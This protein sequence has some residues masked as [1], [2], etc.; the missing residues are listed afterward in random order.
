MAR[1]RE[2]GT[3]VSVDSRIMFRKLWNMVSKKKEIDTNIFDTA[4][5]TDI[6]RLFNSPS[7]G[8]SPVA[9]ACI[10]ILTDNIAGSDM[11]VV[12]NVSNERQPQ[13]EPILEH[14]LKLLLDNP[15]R[16]WD[17][18]SFWNW[19]FRCLFST[20]NA[21][22][23]I[24]RKGNMGRAVELVPAKSQ[25]QLEDGARMVHIFE[26]GQWV[27]QQRPVRSQD[28]LEMHL[29]D[30]DGA[31]AISPLGRAAKV[32]DL[33]NAIVL[34][35][36]NMIKK[37]LHFKT[38]LV[39]DVMTPDKTPEQRKAISDAIKEYSSGVDSAGKMLILP[40]GM[41]PMQ[42]G[43]MSA[44]DMQIMNIL[45]WGILEI[46]R[47]WRVPPRMIF[48]GEKTKPTNASVET[49]SEDF[50]RLTLAPHFKR[51][52]SAMCKKLLTMAEKAAAYKVVVSSDE[53]RQGSWTERAFVA[54]LLAT[55]GGLITINEARAILGRPPLDEGDRLINPTGTAEQGI[56]DADVDTDADAGTDDD[57]VIRIRNELGLDLGDLRG[58]DTQQNHYGS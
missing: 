44:N 29:N 37:G 6:Y 28:I 41:S 25:G 15:F 47:V 21:Y 11:Q 39:S 18:L 10:D 32:V 45:Q 56:G 26:R 24:R 22:A 27:H 17:A 19:Y 50:Y 5:L 8:E 16:E 38:A 55:R 9:T 53:L 51:A 58:Y 49:Q 57:N 20:G 13:Y 35:N 30:F 33:V 42:I 40:K 7:G 3:T 52:E 46:C 36:S 34:Y 31:D 48:H 14:P 12:Q 23:V 2:V 4:R 43:G 54:Q 1:N